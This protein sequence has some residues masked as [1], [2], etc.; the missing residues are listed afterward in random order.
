MRKSIV[1]FG[2]LL[3]R[4]SP[5]R[6]EKLVQ[7]DDYQV[8]FTGGEANVGVSCVN[9][10]MDAYVVSRV[11]AHEIGQ[12]C[13]NY[14]RRY[15][16][17]TR[18]ISRGG[19]RLA[20]LYT[21]TGCSQRPSRVIYDRDHS[22]FSEIT[23]GTFDWE[24]ILRD[25]D[26]FHFTGTAPAMGESVTREL[27]RGLKLAREA[28]LTVSV[29]YN[30]R[31]KLWDRETARRTMEQLMEYVDVGIG[32][33][34]DCEAV[35]GIHADGT[36]FENG[37]VD[38]RS[39]SL[40]ASKMVHRYGLKMQAITLRESLSASRNGWSAILHDGERCYDGPHYTVDLVD[41]IGGGDSFSGGLI[42]GL[43][44]GMEKQEALDF[45]VAASC[46]KQT[47][48][49]DFNLSAKEDVLS[50]MRGNASGRVQR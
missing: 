27:L 10:G 39:Y 46:L 25:K 47:I 42:Y 37:S 31:S 13:V 12:A 36:D 15:G 41:R 38:Q 28:G 30:F 20:I 19:N 24:T 22:S 48:E 3:E 11:P 43:C 21:E 44:S 6:Y 9:Y 50:L 16:L 29:D 45:A 14:L 7:A 34:E 18:Y 32:N 33:E 4:L 40:V 23:E 8:R 26:W 35:F 1:L 5:P 49:G 17:D 2:D